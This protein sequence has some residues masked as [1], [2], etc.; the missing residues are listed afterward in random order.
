MIIITIYLVRE[1]IHLS[2]KC[3]LVSHNC[4]Y[5]RFPNQ[6]QNFCH[7]WH[8]CFNKLT[9]N[10]YIGKKGKLILKFI[11]F[12]LYRI[13]SYDCRLE[14]VLCN[15]YKIR[16]KQIR[17]RSH[18]TYRYI[19]FFGDQYLSIRRRYIHNLNVIHTS[20]YGIGK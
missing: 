7:H 19:L 15:T 20:T 12:I 13:L 16:I 18:P 4:L 6:K 8:V 17:E 5:N 9:Y 2:N 3:S 14:Y 11:K 10:L 1:F